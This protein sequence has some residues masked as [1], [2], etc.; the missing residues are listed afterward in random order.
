M[1]KVYESPGILQELASPKPSA[2]EFYLKRQ[3]PK[4]EHDLWNYDYAGKVQEEGGNKKV[5][6]DDINKYSPC[7]QGR[8]FYWH[9]EKMKPYVHP[10]TATKRNVMIRPVIKGV[11][12]GFRIT[13]K[14][15]TDMELGRLLWTLSFGNSQTHAHK[16]GMG[17]PLGLGSVR[18]SFSKVINRVILSTDTLVY[19][20]TDQTNAF[21][22]YLQGM[23]DYLGCSKEVLDAY[24]LI[25]DF[26]NC[27]KNIQYP[28]N[29]N[30]EGKHYEWFSSNKTDSVINQHLEPL[31]SGSI[32]LEKYD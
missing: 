28:T 23:E 32:E 15:I 2:T 25:H 12:F 30:K 17:K 27:L 7:I 8:K 3:K 14:N 26:E 19:E 21:R 24:L 13:Y 16:I 31:N 5:V 6:Y 1:K 9:H 10:N 29:M 20:L 18:I 22:D 4:G 11:K